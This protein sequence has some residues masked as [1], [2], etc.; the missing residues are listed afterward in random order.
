M[1]G[2]PPATEPITLPASYLTQLAGLLATIDAF[3]R[4][5]PQ[6]TSTLARHLGGDHYDAHALIDQAAFTAEY[7]R[8]LTSTVNGHRPGAGHAP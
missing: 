3:F 2:P 1:H 5:S 8:S 4:A 7:L 6:A